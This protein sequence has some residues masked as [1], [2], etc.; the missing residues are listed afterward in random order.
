MLRLNYF[1]IPVE[2]EEE[3][4]IRNLYEE[5]EMPLEQVMAKYQNDLL[6][7]INKLKDEDDKA[8]VSPMLR[9]R[10]SCSA[11]AS[12]SGAG[13]SSN[14]STSQIIEPGNG[15]SD[16]EEDSS[17]SSS[18]GQ[19]SSSSSKQTNSSSSNGDS[20]PVE[21]EDTNEKTG[22]EKSVDK[23]SDEQEDIKAK[24][25]SGCAEVSEKPKDIKVKKDKS[26]D[27]NN[28]GVEVNGEIGD[29]EKKGMNGDLAEGEGGKGKEKAKLKPS[30]RRKRVAAFRS[31]LEVLND[32]DSESDDG[33]ENFEGGEENR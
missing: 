20:K 15:S 32:S 12:S 29:E 1:C 16:P 22:D 25:N 26:G 8:L 17:R 28:Q 9:A 6:N 14:C 2:D 19:S 18:E 23:I 13:S 31:L 27:E 11:G 24:D 30:M 4:N 3:E 33:D 21:T 5:A 10:R 7:N